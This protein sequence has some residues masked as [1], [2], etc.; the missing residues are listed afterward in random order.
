VNETCSL[1]A[2]SARVAEHQR[3]TVLY[4]TLRLCGPCWLSF[5][6]WLQ[7]AAERPRRILEGSDRDF[8]EE[9]GTC[10]EDRT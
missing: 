4:R 5:M 7:R 3:I 1:C 6:D 10:R 9:R 2:R 8:V